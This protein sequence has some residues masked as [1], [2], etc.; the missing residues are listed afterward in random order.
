VTPQVRLVVFDMIGTTIQATDAVPQAF[1][2]ALAPEGV[3]VDAGMVTRVR[4]LNKRTAIAA[5]VPEGADHA[6][7]SEAAYRHFERAL[8]DAYGP[9]S[10]SPVP[11]SG[12]VARP[13]SAWRST[14]ASSVHSRRTS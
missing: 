11:A 13:V 6:A 1:A 12:A 9:G 4:G 8:L 2:T 5:L 7:R 14:P 3:E 10:L